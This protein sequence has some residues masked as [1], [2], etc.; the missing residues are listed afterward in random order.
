MSHMSNS[1]F[2]AVQPATTPDL[3]DAGLAQHIDNAREPI[4]V[5]L[6]IAGSGSQ[7]ALDLQR[8]QECAGDADP[9]VAMAGQVGSQ[10]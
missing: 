6:E 3:A 5:I 1:G 10:V 9:A 7:I 8:L 2:D 4:G